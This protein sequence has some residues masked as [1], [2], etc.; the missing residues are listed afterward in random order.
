M[1]PRPWPESKAM[2]GV[3]GILQP[4]PHSCPHFLLCMTGQHASPGESLACS[5]IRAAHA[6]PTMHIRVRKQ[7]QPK[8]VAGTHLISVAA[9]VGQGVAYS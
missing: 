8:P 3:Y 9:C 1:S 5:Q 4:C 7:T 2:A 6:T